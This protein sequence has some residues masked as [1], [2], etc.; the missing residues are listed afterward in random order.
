MVW[1]KKRADPPWT[2]P[3]PILPAALVVAAN[4]KANLGLP[5]IAS[6][7]TAFPGSVRTLRPRPRVQRGAAGKCVRKD[8]SIGDFLRS[9]FRSLTSTPYTPFGSLLCHDLPGFLY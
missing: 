9:L 7:S 8:A 3:L 4:R 1:I 6:G 5:R 2:D